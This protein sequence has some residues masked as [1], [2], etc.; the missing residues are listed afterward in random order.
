MPQVH[1]RNSRPR[2]LLLPIGVLLLVVAMGCGRPAS[3]PFD[4]VSPPPLD[5]K[6]LCARLDDVLRHAR[7]GR[8]LDATE[9]A[10]WQVV[11][12]I[13]AFGRDFRLSHDGTTSPALEYL[14]DGGRLSGWTL[15]PG[16]VGLVAVLDAGSK[17]GQG[18]PD[19]W[20]GYLSQC[21]LES[22]PLDTE[23]TVAERTFHVSD[24]L[25]Q[26]KHDIR[27]GQEATWTLMALSTYLPHDAT[28]TA[29]DGEPWSLERLVEMEASASLADSACGGSHRLFGLAV[30][31]NRYLAAT[32]LTPEQLTGGWASAEQRIQEGIERARRFQQPDGSFSTA[33]FDRPSTSPDVFAR[34]GS[35]GHVFEFL[36]MA[37]EQQRLSEPWVL[38]A[39]EALLTLLEQTAD[40]PVECGGLYHAAHGLVLYRARQC[41]DSDDVERS[42]AVTPDGSM[43]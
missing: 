25:E 8:Q 38:R 33:F 24:L 17:T 39:A 36:A 13:L 37:L 28:W 22:M 2:W 19:Q 21:S 16:S 10:A 23:V 31:L 15:R 43:D 9:H 12:G 32:G 5:Q 20:L 6:S 40:V 7:D 1:P 41:G 34:I 3:P 18:H 26:A 35:T 29:G 30:A 4:A 42:A 11:H 14:L 27:P